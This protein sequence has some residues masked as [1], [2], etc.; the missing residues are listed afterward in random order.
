VNTVLGIVLL[1]TNGAITGAV[2]VGAYQSVDAC[3]QALVDELTQAKDQIPQG[4]KAVGSCLDF[5]HDLN[6]TA[7]PKTR[8]APGQTEI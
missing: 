2:P 7:A 4:V 3:H 5:T 6:P 1:I 8:T